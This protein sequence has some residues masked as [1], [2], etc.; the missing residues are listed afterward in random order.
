MQAAV[1]QVFSQELADLK[2]G[3]NPNEAIHEIERGAPEFP[4]IA[5]LNGT[6]S[7]EFCNH[8]KLLQALSSLGITGHVVSLIHKMLLT[9]VSIEGKVEPKTTVGMLSSC[10][11][12][13]VLI[14]VLFHEFDQMMAE[15]G[16]TFVRV[17]AC[18]VIQN[19][20][21]KAAERAIANASKFMIK[22]LFVRVAP[23][24]CWSGLSA[25]Q[26]TWRNWLK[27]ADQP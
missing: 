1:A 23:E 2:S 11:L 6:T 26:T 13:P 16:K 3:L 5:A 7:L 21:A 27:A 19:K 10:P 15:R 4:W 14:D 9:P 24:D 12:R 25:A 17:G 20:S 8:S 18:V 22:K